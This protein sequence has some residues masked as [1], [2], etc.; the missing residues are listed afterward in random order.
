MSPTES[1][2]VEPLAPV[3]RRVIAYV[4]GFNLYFGL[5]EKGWK[6]HYWLDIQELATRLMQPD[7]ELVSVKYFTARISSFF[8]PRTGSL[9]QARIYQLQQP[10]SPQ[11]K[12]ERQKVFLEALETLPKVRI[13]YGKYYFNPETCEHCGAR[14]QV[15]KEKMS[16]VNIAVE[17]LVDAYEDQFDTAMLIS[18]DSDLVGPVEAVRR[19]FPKKR[20]VVIFPPA[21][22]SGELEGA[23]HAHLVIGQGTLKKCHLPETI[24]KPDGYVLRRPD[25]WQ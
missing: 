10:S 13:I 5:R 12:G 16:D 11:S 14:T 17:M 6:R 1:I 19:L 8:V 3:K 9:P 18:A 22:Q 24:T 7:Q 2:S 4:D 20:V 23:A 25:S 21:R 15:P